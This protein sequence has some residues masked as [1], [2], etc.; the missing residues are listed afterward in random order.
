MKLS[1]RIGLLC[2]VAMTVINQFAAVPFLSG[3]LAGI[4]ICLLIMGM[5]PQKSVDTLKNWKRAILRQV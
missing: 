4:G 2:V 3:L 5:L 1:T